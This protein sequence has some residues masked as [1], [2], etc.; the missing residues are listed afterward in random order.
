MNTTKEWILKLNELKD[1]LNRNPTLID[2][3]S[4]FPEFNTIEI[5]DSLILRMELYGKSSNISEGHQG[6]GSR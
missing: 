4:D 6:T 2:I 1:F 3:E 5:I